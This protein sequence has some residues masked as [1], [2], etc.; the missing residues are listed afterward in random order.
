M[1]NTFV[2]VPYEHAT[3][4]VCTILLPITFDTVVQN[5]VAQNARPGK[6]F[7]S[8]SPVSVGHFFFS[9]FLFSHEPSH[10]TVVPI[11]MAEC[12]RMQC[13]YVRLDG[14]AADGEVVERTEVK[15]LVKMEVL[16]QF[17]ASR[18]VLRCA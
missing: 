9:I 7:D 1:R 8:I 13:A 3:P 17:G 4:S 16:P 12:L 2:D 10:L 14:E 15:R 6:D 5:V 11:P 18:L